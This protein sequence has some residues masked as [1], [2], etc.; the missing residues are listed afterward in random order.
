MVGKKAP[1]V[2]DAD[3]V[4]AVHADAGSDARAVAAAARAYAGG[5]GA[6]AVMRM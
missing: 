4:V 3:G 6:H 2:V 1:T 5:D